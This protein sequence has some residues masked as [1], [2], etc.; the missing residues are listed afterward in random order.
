MSLHNSED[1]FFLMPNYCKEEFKYIS[2]LIDAANTKFVLYVEIKKNRNLNINFNTLLF[3]AKKLNFH[4]FSICSEPLNSNI[5]YFDK[6]KHDNFFIFGTRE[7]ML[8]V[9]SLPKISIQNISVLP[10][11]INTS[12]NCK[13]DTLFISFLRNQFNPIISYN[14]LITN[15]SKI[16]L[17]IFSNNS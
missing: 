12:K 9:F 8:R 10:N 17:D 1:D 3:K 15:I 7:L 5:K 2:N 16:N 4:H 11:V 13:F 6:T 14:D